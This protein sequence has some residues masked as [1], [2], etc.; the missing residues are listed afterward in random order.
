MK[1]RRDFLKLSTLAGAAT[2]LPLSNLLGNNSSVCGLMPSETE[3]PFP[4]PGGEITNP[5]N[6]VDIRGGQTGVQTDFILTVVD[7]ATCTPLQFV[8]VDIW[9]CSKDG[10]YSGYGNFTGQFWLRGYQTTDVNGQVMFTTIYPG[11]YPG[12]ATH[13]H[14]ELFYN[15]IMIKTSQFCFDETVNDVVHLSPG[16]TGTN[17]TTNMSDGIFN[18]SAAHMAIETMAIS[19]DVVNGYTGTLT[20]G[21]NGIPLSDQKSIV[22]NNI[23]LRNNPVADYLV[24]DH[25]NSPS[26]AIKIF[27]TQGTLVLEGIITSGNSTEIYTGKLSKGIYSVVI[28]KNGNHEMLRFVKL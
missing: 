17:P 12:R 10:D 19:G 25:P 14:F 21:V 15:N 6:I 23:R 27:N 8:R 28:N 13:V 7:A 16:Y 3:G 26:S 24:I 2:L 22:K 9:H 1:N 4:Y 11:W 20:I 5:L 18:N